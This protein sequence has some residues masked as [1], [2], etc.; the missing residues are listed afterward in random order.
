MASGWS[1]VGLNPA[2]KEKGFSVKNA[3][4]ED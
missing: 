2:A 3:T 4:P 1:P